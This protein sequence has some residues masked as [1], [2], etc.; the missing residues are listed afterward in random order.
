MGPAGVSAAQA[1]GR[2]GMDLAPEL[3]PWLCP[4]SCVGR[5]A[6]HGNEAARGLSVNAALGSSLGK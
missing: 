1:P 3:R 5:A 4:E 2:G 6:R